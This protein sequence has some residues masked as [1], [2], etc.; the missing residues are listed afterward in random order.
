MRNEPDVDPETGKPWSSR[1]L[2]DCLRRGAEL[3]GWADRPPAGHRDGDWLVGTGVAS[4][5]Y[6]TMRQAKST[7]R[8][9]YAVGRYVTEIGSAD[10]GTGAWTVLPQ[11]AADALGVELLA[12]ADAPSERDLVVHASATAAGLQRSLELL[13]VEGTVLDLSWYGDRPVTLDL[14]G[15]F[16][17]RRL[18]IRSS[19]VGMVAAPMRDHVTHRDR[20]ALALDH[21]WDPAFDALL[22]G[23][24]PFEELPETMARLA[25]G[26]PAL[27]H[28][29]DYEGAPS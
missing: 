17:S 16:H 23:R 8:V 25:A 18:T 6:P 12:P 13:A 7:A 1:H 9:R 14:G 24:S 11:I 2:V 5:V 19:Q 20:L 15:V 28:T 22:T 21:L 29:I 4:S 3:F 27:C 10:L 26:E